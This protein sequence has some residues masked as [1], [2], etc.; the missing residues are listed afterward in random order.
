MEYQK[1]IVLH[2]VYKLFYEHLLFKESFDL[3]DVI[4]KKFDSSSDKRFNRE[5][6]QKLL[7]NGLQLDRNS[8]MQDTIQFFKEFEAPK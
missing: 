3:Y 4:F 2:K 7:I 6:F 1:T 5:E 8:A